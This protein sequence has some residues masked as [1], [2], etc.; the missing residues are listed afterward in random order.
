[1]KMV[2][3]K[4]LEKILK[5]FNKEE[6][7]GGYLYFLHKNELIQLDLV[8]YSCCTVCSIED[9]KSTEFIRD[10]MTMEGIYIE[11]KEGKYEE[12]DSIWIGEYGVQM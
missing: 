4:E 6:L 7:G 10:E 2:Q 8:D 12:I 1:M 11:I 5:K 9:I 3:R